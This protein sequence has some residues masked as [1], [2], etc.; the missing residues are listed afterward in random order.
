[1]TH[2]GSI[3]I[4]SDAKVEAESAVSGC[5]LRVGQVRQPVLGVPIDAI[6]MDEFLTTIDGWIAGRERHYVCTLD[7]HALMHS[8]E[9]P[10][11]R[12]I[13]R[14]ASMATPD[15]MPLVWLLRQ[16]GHRHAERVCG[17]DLMPALFR[18]S[19]QMGHR[20]FLYGSSER[21]LSLLTE[22]IRARFP[23]A[24][25]AGSY[26]PPYRELTPTEEDEMLSRLNAAKPDI[27]WV[28]LGAPKQDR[29][30]AAYRDRLNAPVLI[31][32][33]AAFDFMA[34]TGR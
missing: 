34:G 8:H 4:L 3:A 12:H 9:A 30:M 11:V 7:V 10:D 26:S 13:Y 32:V 1:V 22:Q 31:G 20:H 2:A 27:V 6:S 18:R 5:G 17:P 15:G 21:T 24:I 33:G 14:S 25:V 28:G 19:Q 23:D 16:A 29:W